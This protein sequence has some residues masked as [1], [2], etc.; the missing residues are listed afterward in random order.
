[1]AIDA[2]GAIYFCVSTGVY[3]LLSGATIRVTVATGFTTPVGIAVD[4]AGNVYVADPGAG[5]ITKVL[6]SNGSKVILATVDNTLT[7]VAVDSYGN[8]Y[9]SDSN[10]SIMVI[11][12]AGG[13][14]L[15]VCSSLVNHKVLAVDK[16]ANAYTD[17][18]LTIDQV[19]F[20]YFAVS[21][22]LPAGLNIDP[23]TGIISGSPIRTSA[24][25][26]YT[27]T[28]NNN[29]GNGSATINLAVAAAS[30]PNISYTTPQT[31]TVGTSVS[32]SPVNTGGAVPA[33]QAIKLIRNT[34]LHGWA[35]VLDASG[36]IYLSFG[37]TTIRKYTPDGSSFVNIGSGFSST[38]G[39]ALDAAGNLYVVDNGNGA[40]KE[41]LASNGSIIT[42]ATFIANETAAVAVDLQGNLFVTSGEKLFEI[43]AGGS[44]PVTL[45]SGLN[46]P[47]G[48]VVDASDNVYFCNAGGKTIRELP[49]GS[50]SSIVVASGFVAPDFL[51]MDTSDNLFVSDNGANLIKKIPGGGGA[52]FALPLTFLTPGP[53]T[54]DPTGNLYL[55]NYGDTTIYAVNPGYYNISPALPAGLSMDPSTGIISGIPTV[56]SPK[57]NYTIS[58][59]NSGGY[60]VATIEITINPVPAPT[61][62]YVSPD[63]YAVN[64]AIQPLAPNTNI[65]FNPNYLPVVNPT[66]FASGLGTP[67]AITTDAAGN[68]YLADYSAGTVVKI[69]LNGGTATT[70]LTVKGP[71][72]VAVDAAG[73]VF[74]TAYNSPVSVYKIAPG[75]TVTDIGSGDFQG[76]HSISVDAQGNAY[77]LDL[78][79]YLYEIPAGSTTPT[80][81][82]QFDA[83]NDMV[84]DAAGNLYAIGSGTSGSI[85]EFPASNRNTHITVETGITNGTTIAIDK[86]GN[87]YYAAAAA[88]VYEVV[89]G[90][91]PIKIYSTPGYCAIDGTGN[92][93]V[94]E[95]NVG[96]IVKGTRQTGFFINGILPAGLNFS[97][98]TGVVS[99]TPTVTS[100]ATNY[101]VTG[102]NTAGGASAI[103]NIAT[104]GATNTSLTNLAVSSGTLSPSF[105]TATTSYTVAEPYTTSS[106][107]VTPI[108]GDGTASILV[109]GTAVASGSASA[110]I[111]LAIGANTIY[112]S[113]TDNGGTTA[114]NYT[115]TATR[116]G[117]DALA[118]FTVSPGTISPAFASGAYSYSTTLP[119]GAG[120]ITVTPTAADSTATITVNGKGIAS[121]TASPNIQLAVGSNTI[122][123]VVT[124]AD[125]TASQTYA[126]TALRPSAN[127]NLSSLSLSTGALSPT[128]NANTLSYTSA[129]ANTVTTATVKPT[130]S[131]GNATVKV[132]GTTVTSGTNS[133]PI[134]LNVGANVINVAVTAQDGSTTKTY[135]ITVTR[136]ASGNASL[137]TFKISRGTLTPAF[138]STTTSYTASVVNGVASMTVT[139]TAA[140]STATITVD[141]TAVVSGDASGSIALAVGS[142]TIT[143]IVTAPDGVTTQTYTLV[144]T[145]AS[146]SADSFDPGISVSTPIAIGAEETPAL[147][148]DGVV[149]HQAISP[150]GDGINDFLTIDNISQYPDNKL[151]IVNRSGQTIY[152]ATGYDNSSKVFDGHSN[153]NGQMQLPGTYFY[154]LDYTVKGIT[155][156]KTG[157][158]VLKY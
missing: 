34:A 59:H 17:N 131:D 31:F 119:A 147:A 124:T 116:T 144:V 118:N 33:E 120:A 14:I 112:I 8:V 140:A 158:I 52:P 76:P 58:T 47:L 101:T 24:A 125:G 20:G 152:Q 55:D 141:G 44:T 23:S 142:N 117:S 134:S 49:A 46:D 103:V 54:A 65:V 40:I 61:I 149:V 127:A 74:I 143:T 45:L 71:T 85:Y 29:A 77:F 121:G 53:I 19:P 32:I 18:G 129:V 72:G 155:K 48:L 110:A 99:G 83:L 22:A 51:T 86:G 12:A 10:T 13:P 69:T 7:G 66:T 82:T 27:V 25:A 36:N 95:Y 105:A 153:K 138:S 37:G 84:T 89:P 60:S 94:S 90:L 50:S 43:P 108:A 64:T 75:G 91:N 1:M 15:P 80:E 41:I 148:D 150:N 154:E 78:Y 100:P 111:P 56:V 30:K 88:G 42:I 132:N 38:T 3:K 16:S 113:V 57:T 63:V 2:A 68:V 39:I 106:I 28:A 97:G 107:T 145:R 139:P 92:L 137:A 81:L 130:T 98:T 73:N 123:T 11:P 70:L 135:S 102:Y 133:S 87:I 115:L 126:L 114:S 96:S 136:A 4:A 122:T 156:T 6:A 146:G 5:T 67:K 104:V 128:F 109:N 93:Y 35:I 26:N 62:S 151:T 79:R 9:F 21:P 157:F